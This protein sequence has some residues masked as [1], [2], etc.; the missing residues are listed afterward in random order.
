MLHMIPILISLVTARDSIHLLTE[1][2]KKISLR[3][4]KHL[5]IGTGY[6]IS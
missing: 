2:H 6:R 1:G 4:M 5:T 3:T